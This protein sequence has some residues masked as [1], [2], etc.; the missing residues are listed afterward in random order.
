[1]KSKL[2]VLPILCMFLLA[3]SG[4]LPSCTICGLPPACPICQRYTATVQ[5]FKD[6]LIE[7]TLVGFDGCVV[8]HSNRDKTC[9]LIVVVSI[10]PLS[11]FPIT[12]VPESFDLNGPP[13]AFDFYGEEIYS[14]YGTPVVDYY[15]GNGWWM[16]SVS[17]SAMSD[18]WCQAPA[19]NFSYCYSGVFSATIK[20]M[21]PYGYYMVVGTANFAG[22]G[23]DL[24]DEDGDGYSSDVDC[25]DY[26]PNVNPGQP[27][28]CTGMYWDRN[29][30]GIPD[31]QECGGGGGSCP[32]APYVCY[33]Y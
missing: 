3:S 17:A 5:W 27:P 15:D 13:G 6:N 9:S 20:Q 7:T 4:C 12:A 32:P 30:D 1:M 24:P 31:N 19:P 26:D 2:L 25:N 22:Y 8:V 21:T 16:G 14:S 11:A 18:G 29:C 33:L 10:Q 28:D 23:R